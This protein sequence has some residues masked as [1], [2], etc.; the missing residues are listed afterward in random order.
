[1]ELVAEV[2]VDAGYQVV[3]A[4]DGH[5]ALAAV[6]RHAV[7]LIV[8]DLMMPG[9]DGWQLV[10]EVRAEDA[11]RA[12][13]L[14]L[15]TAGQQLPFDSDALDSATAVVRKPFSIDQLLEHVGSMLGG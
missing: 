10:Q 13:P 4:R 7:Q 3:T 2:L 9:L 14:I 5:A 11:W 12:L 6:R 1:V 15:M 8:S